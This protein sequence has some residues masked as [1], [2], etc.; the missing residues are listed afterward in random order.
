VRSLHHRAAWM[1]QQQSAQSVQARQGHSHIESL[2]DKRDR[3]IQAAAAAKQSN[4]GAPSATAEAAA[5]AN[6]D[7]APSPAALAA[8]S[9]DAPAKPAPTKGP[10]YYLSKIKAMLQHYTLS[11]KLLWKDA[12]TARAIRKKSV[13]TAGHPSARLPLLWSPAAAHHRQA[14]V[15]VRVAWL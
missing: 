13:A 4:D 6:A 5:A 15:S 9:P 12:K 2:H 10:R 7:T 3:N 1:H 14:R 11:A 8:I